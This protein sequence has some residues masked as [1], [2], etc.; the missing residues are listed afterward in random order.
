[1]TDYAFAYTRAVAF[2]NTL[3][4][5][6]VKHVRM[7]LRRPQGKREGRTAQLNLVR[8]MGMRPD[9]RSNHTHSRAFDRFLDTYNH[10]RS[11]TQLGGGPTT[12][13]VNTARVTTTQPR[14]T[15]KRELTV[16]SQGSLR[17]S[18]L[19]FVGQRDFH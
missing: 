5:F 1:M 3:A 12:F 2:R 15:P 14:R 13:R 19:N 4:R 9:F 16:F 10:H 7:R 17:K 18:S 11:H 6:G 8:G